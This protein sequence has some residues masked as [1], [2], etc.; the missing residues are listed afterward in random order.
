MRCPHCG[1]PIQS[2]HSFCVICGGDLL[3]YQPV[4]PL[5]TAKTAVAQAGQRIQN[6]LQTP[7]RGRK[8][9]APQ[10]VPGS[11][12]DPAHGIR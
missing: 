5:Q 1:E 11:P 9:A 3:E 6:A 12:A 8:Q 2:R 7:V 10:T 4:S